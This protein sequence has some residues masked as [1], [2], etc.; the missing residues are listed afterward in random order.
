MNAKRHAA[1]SRRSPIVLAVG[2]FAAL[3]CTTV[4]EAGEVEFTFGGVLTELGPPPPT[5]P[6]P[7]GDVVA[8]DSWSMTYVFETTTGD[9]Y[10]S[11]HRAFYVDAVTSATL[12]ID[13][14]SVD[15]LFAPGIIDV[16]ND[17]P[18]GYDQYEVGIIFDLGPAPALPMEWFMQLDGTNS[19]WPTDALPLC[20]DIQLPLFTLNRDFLV[21]IGGQPT[22]M[23]SIDSFVCG[24]HETVTDCNEN[25]I[26]DAEEP[27]S[28]HMFC[29]EPCP[30]PCSDGTEWSLE[31]RIP[32]GPVFAQANC[33]AVPP[34]GSTEVEMSQGLVDCIN[35]TICSGM[36]ATLF[37]GQPCFTI[38][39]PGPDPVELCVGPAGGAADCCIDSVPDGWPRPVC[40]FN[41]TLAHVEVVNDDCNENQVED[42]IDIALET[43]ADNNE[44]GIPDECGACCSP[45]PCRHTLP[46]S[47]VGGAYRGDATNC[48]LEAC[49]GI[50]AVSEW[51]LAVML[52][53][54]LAAGTVVVMQRKCATARR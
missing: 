27:V 31:V 6:W 9:T 50:P 18:E 34:E 36:S 41:P 23:G 25:G 40:Q 17:Y 12:T 45:G 28:T 8:G 48:E 35:A 3:G 16:F 39:V 42:G 51:G 11:P 38:N 33:P 14:I 1:E 54:I 19:A 5:E 30:P 4:L 47:C 43:S 26:P 44:D 2:V 20:D 10:P 37:E 24:P 46:G 49:D 52:L 53:L 29:I 7:W 21:G 32:G 13:D 22:I 15:T